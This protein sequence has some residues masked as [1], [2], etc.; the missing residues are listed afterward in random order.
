MSS[1]LAEVSYSFL[2]DRALLAFDSVLHTESPASFL[3][4]RS[5]VVSP[6]PD[7]GVASP[8][9]TW[10]LQG[11]RALVTMTSEAKASVLPYVERQVPY[12]VCF[13]SFASMVATQANVKEGGLL[14]W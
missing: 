2:F 3:Y 13:A 9:M 4:I 6:V 5:S 7:E 10:S 12:R 14:P 1:S 11:A 8:T